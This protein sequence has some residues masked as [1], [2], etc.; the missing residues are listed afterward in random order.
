MDETSCLACHVGPFSPLHST[1][2]IALDKLDEAVHQCLV[3]GIVVLMAFNDG[4]QDLDRLLLVHG[5]NGDSDTIGITASWQRFTFSPMLPAILFHKT[6]EPFIWR[7]PAVGRPI[8]S[9]LVDTDDF[10]VARRVRIRIDCFEL[11][12]AHGKEKQ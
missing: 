6:Y 2:L 11:W 5:E 9:L 7:H 1:C 3:E 4:L 8:D 12:N 10:Y